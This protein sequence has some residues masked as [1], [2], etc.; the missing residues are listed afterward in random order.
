MSQEKKFLIGIG[1][2]TLLL[3][4]GGVF[5]FSRQPQTAS[6]D[7]GQID[8]VGDGKYATGSAQAKVKVVE[9]GD[10]QCPACGTAHPIVKQIIENNKDKIYFVFRNFPLALHLNARDAARAAEAAGEQGKY[11]EMHDKLYETQSEWSEASNPADIFKKYAQEMG[12]DLKKYEED[13]DKVLGRINVDVALGD[14]AG[15]DSTPTFFINNV[16]YPGVIA[17]ERFQQLIDEASK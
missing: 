15:I 3:V 11:W 10:F 7:T 5:F 9:F 8:L 14:K 13:F 6:L 4:F 2:A 1:L 17:A 12:L 16:R